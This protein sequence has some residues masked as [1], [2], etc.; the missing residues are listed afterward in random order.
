MI[1][2][3]MG[4]RRGLDRRTAVR[5]DRHL[6]TVWTGLRLNSDI[7]TGP[8]IEALSPSTRVHEVD[9]LPASWLSVRSSLNADDVSVCLAGIRP[10]ENEMQHLVARGHIGERSAGRCARHE[11]LMLR[12]SPRKNLI[13]LE[14]R[15]RAGVASAAS[16][17]RSGAL[18]G[19]KEHSWLVTAH[20]SLPW[21]SP[22]S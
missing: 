8:E 11:A 20:S 7:G 6:R 2:I 1:A 9:Q 17:G 16:G 10:V 22:D 4:T 14:S 21:R 19:G 15:I 13:I 5:C 3:R 18:A 12:Y